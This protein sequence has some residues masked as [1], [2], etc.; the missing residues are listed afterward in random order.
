MGCHS[1]VFALPGRDSADLQ[2]THDVVP[3]LL[4]GGQADRSG[5]FVSECFLCLCH[6]KDFPRS[7]WQWAA[8]ECPAAS[9]RSIDRQGEAALQL[10]NCTKRPT[11]ERCVAR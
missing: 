2:I 1:W 6:V 8:C 4:L 9:A 10:E 11:V 7:P 5:G 3:P